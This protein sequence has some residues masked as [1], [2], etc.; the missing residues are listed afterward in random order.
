MLYILSGSETA[1]VKRANIITVSGV[2]MIAAII[3][4]YFFGLLELQALTYGLLLAPVFLF[5]GL[6]GMRI[7]RAAP[8]RYYRRVALIALAVISCAM[9]AA[10]LFRLVLHS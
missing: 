5:G 8:E 9:F 3:S 4:M 7:F 2:A 1:E 10:N 6:I